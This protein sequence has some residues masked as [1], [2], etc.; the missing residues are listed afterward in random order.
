MPMHGVRETRPGWA[1]FL[2]FDGPLFFFRHHVMAQDIEIESSDGV[3][4]GSA[5][6]GSK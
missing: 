3:L 6:R 4:P 5:G 2:S 1:M